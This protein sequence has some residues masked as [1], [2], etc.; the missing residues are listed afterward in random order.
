MMNYYVFLVAAGALAWGLAVWGH[1]RVIRRYKSTGD[2][3]HGI[4]VFVEPVRWL[5][6]VWGFASFCRGLRR[7]GRQQLIHLFRWSGRAGALL[8]LPDLMRRG[9]LRARAD[10]L[11]RLIDEL[12]NLHPGATIH[13]CSYSSGCYVAA[14]AIKRARQASRLGA[15]VLLAGTISPAY[16]LRR[17]A[18]RCRAVYT[19][20]SLLDCV[21][22]GLGPM[23]FG[24]NDRRWSPA[25]GM[26]GFK[27]PPRTVRE[28]GWKLNNVH[29]RYFGDHFSVTSSR[30]VAAHVA[31]ALDRA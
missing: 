9:K 16:D 6:I 14:H 24:C 22:N 8:V 18:R 30:F 19:F 12:A 11:A 31:P 27:S 3:R 29:C 25:C 28:H 2:A 7:G 13:V 17:A 5:F 1:C 10:R 21:I 4:V 23:L 20:H 26:V 15:L